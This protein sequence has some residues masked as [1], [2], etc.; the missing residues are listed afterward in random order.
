MTFDIKVS[1]LPNQLTLAIRTIIVVEK[2]PDFFGKAYGSIMKY[3]EELGE[4]P[5]GMPFGTYFNMDM[6]ALEVA[7]GFPR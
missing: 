3:L 4:A 2:L 6:N 7:A 1:E 5:T